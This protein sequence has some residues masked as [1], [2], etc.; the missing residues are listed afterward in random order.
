MTDICNVTWKPNK[1]QIDDLILPEYT[2]MAKKSVEYI[3][4]FQYPPGYV[5]AMLGDIA[6]ALESSHPGSESDCSCC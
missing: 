2:D 5:A 6:D 3:A 4:K 1:S